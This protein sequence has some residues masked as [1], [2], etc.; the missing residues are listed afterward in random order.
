MAIQEVTSWDVAAGSNKAHHPAGPLGRD[1]RRISLS[2]QELQAAIAR[3]R[4]TL[5]APLVGIN[6]TAT[7][8]VLTLTDT[9][10]R[11][12][13]NDTSE[14]Q[15]R[16]R[17]TANNGLMT[18]TGGST[19][20][21]GSNII[22]YGT[23]HATLGDMIFRTAA[24]TWMSWDESAGAFQVNTGV[25][26]K[27]NALTI[28]SSQNTTLSRNLTI[29]D[30]TQLTPTVTI[31]AS[32]T[33]SPRLD[34]SQS[35]GGVRGRIDYQDSGDWFV[36]DSDG[37]VRLRANNTTALE[38]NSSLL[39]TFFGQTLRI[40]DN[41]GSDSQ[42]EFFDDTNNVYRSIIWDDSE[43]AFY[44]EDSVGT[45]Q[46]IGYTVV[47]TAVSTA[48]GSGNKDLSTAIPDWATEVILSFHNFST[49]G[50]VVPVIQVGDGTYVTTGASYLGSATLIANASAVSALHSS[51]TGFLLTGSTWAGTFI[52][53]GVVRLYKQDPTTNVWCIEGAIS[54]SVSGQA[55]NYILSGSIDL[56]GNLD[57]VRLAIGANSYDGGSVGVAWR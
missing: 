37:G 43:S 14:F 42:V 13:P 54:Q 24:N 28:N 55:A 36:M 33:G 44:A 29:G 38:I 49:N 18:I 22:L 27:T 39:M 9:D 17:T 23:S 2:F 4:D 26:A 46:R 45:L 19:A 11:V 40:G 52:M 30:A 50:T 8:V 47:N 16:R 15:I 31:A 48:S 56:T 32:A 10:I 5:P 53:H 7:G 51:G 35:G 34:F 3:W 25:G 1:A 12:G 57:R 41:L 20:G 6:D 21:T